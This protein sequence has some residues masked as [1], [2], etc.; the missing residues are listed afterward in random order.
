LSLL[1]SVQLLRAHGQIAGYLDTTPVGQWRSAL[2]YFP[3]ALAGWRDLAKGIGWTAMLRTSRT[4]VIKGVTGIEADGA[5][6]LDTLRYRTIH[7]TVAAVKANMLLV[8]EGVV[9]N[10]H[11]ALMLGCQVAWSAA[12]ECYVPRIDEWGESSQANLFIAG[13]S[14][15]IGGAKAAQL[16]G[17]LAALR[18]AVK[19][20]CMSADAANHAARPIRRSLERQ[21]SIRPFLDALF[22]PRP[23]VFAP[24]DPTVICRCEE[25]TAGE[26]RAAARVGCPG[27]NQIKAAT[28][29]G[30][31]PCQGRQC[32]YSVTRILAAAQQRTPAAVGFFHIRPPLQPIT[33]GELATLHKPPH[34]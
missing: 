16:R 28:R 14:A 30:M 8:H 1:Y 33:L 10:L 18:I 25:V 29:A 27:P 26:I 19:S 32:G 7:G 23:Q 13:D 3:A 2:P 20:D 5:G 9:P 4:P 21:L 17:E 11:A 6:R 12:Q 31:G 15:G 22:R 24:D 34:S